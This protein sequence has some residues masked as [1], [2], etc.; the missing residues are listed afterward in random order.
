MSETEG[1]AEGSRRADCAST[2]GEVDE[3]PGRWV[4]RHVVPQALPEPGAGGVAALGGLRIREL[5]ARS[6][7]SPKRPVPPAVGEPAGHAASLAD[8]EPGGCSIRGA[9]G[10][11]AELHN[12]RT[13]PS[14]RRRG[15][16]GRRLR[17]SS[18]SY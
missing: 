17:R 7:V 4:R 16:P 15:A 9:V 10:R 2:E 18:Y 14:A 13:P 8:D 3:H 1:Y 5:A 11:P 12:Y 6:G